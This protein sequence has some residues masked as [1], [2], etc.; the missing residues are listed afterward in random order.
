MMSRRLLHALPLCLLAST[1][2]AQSVESGLAKCQR[3][4]APFVPNGGYASAEAMKEA[5]GEL[6]GYFDGINDYILCL[7]DEY[8][9]ARAEA[10]QIQAQWK[11]AQ[12]RFRTR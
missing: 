10:E 12:E 9:R 11:Y 5:S 2:A 6:R 8:N 4:T 1:T 3:P 7:R